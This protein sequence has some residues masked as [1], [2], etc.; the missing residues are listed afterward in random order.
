M[1][2][3]TQI[4]QKYTQTIAPMAPED[5]NNMIIFILL[6]FSSS[7]IFVLPEDMS[8]SSILLTTC[9]FYL[10]LSL[11]AAHILTN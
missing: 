6:S 5:L 2:S 11:P 9:C 1:R 7:S 8:Y 3:L 10:T 4:N